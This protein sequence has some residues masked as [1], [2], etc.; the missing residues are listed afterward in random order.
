MHV[1]V[2]TACDLDYT[3]VAP[4][5]CRSALAFDN[6]IARTSLDSG[7]RD[8]GGLNLFHGL[9]QKTGQ[10]NE[11]A[12]AGEW[13]TLIRDTVKYLPDIRDPSQC[14]YT[15]C[16]C[17]GVFQT[18]APLLFLICNALSARL[19]PCQQCV[20]IPPTQSAAV[21]SSCGKSILAWLSDLCEGGNGLVL[22]GRN[23][24]EHF[25]GPSRLPKRFANSYST[26]ENEHKQWIA[27]VYEA[28]L[29][30]FQYGKLP[31]DWKLWWS[32]PSD[33]FVGDFLSCRVGRTRKLSRV[34][35]E[36]G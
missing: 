18:R 5:I 24:K 25:R 35:H 23:E 11:R 19:V 30:N 6:D 8:E 4:A 16:L 36:L 2:G 29:I 3:W 1:A 15:E 31:T 26:T 10:A 33:K 20:A 32:E 9:A 21:L 22:Y 34:F 13:Q 14:G 27:T 17:S 12:I 28:R 7:M